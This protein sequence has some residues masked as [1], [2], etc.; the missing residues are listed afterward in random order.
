VVVGQHEAVEEMMIAI[1]C[2]SHALVESNPGLQKHL[3]SAQY[4]KHWIL[5]QQD[6]VARLTLCR[7]I[8]LVLIS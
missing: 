3:L 7:R 6:T 5:I 4:Q 1:L 2:N 8:L